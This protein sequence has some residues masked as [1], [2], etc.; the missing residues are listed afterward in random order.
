MSTFSFSFSGDDIEDINTNSDPS[1]YD[2]LPAP[3]HFAETGTLHR[4]T[5]S[6]SAFPISG[7]ALLPPNHHDL[8]SMLSALPSKISYSTLIVNLDG[9]DEVR[10]PR[11]ELWDVRVQLMAEE[12]EEEQL[13]NLGKDDVRTGI[14]EGGFKS[15]ESSVDLVRVLE[16][17]RPVSGG[18][19]E[20]RFSIFDSWVWER[21]VD[22][23][24]F[25]LAV[26]LLY[27]LLPSSSG[28]YR[29]GWGDS[30]SV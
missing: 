18:F 29:M 23:R 2:F 10:I 21:D 30:I 17:R 1:H 5:N 12:D 19:L 16:G 8:Q 7:Q 3:N 4:A 28:C 6:P 24:Y 20:V 13:G 22:V 26:G 14:Y 9:G 25:S 11:R 27:L 15:W